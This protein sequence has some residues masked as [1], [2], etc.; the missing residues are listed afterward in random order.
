MRQ[1][2]IDFDILVLSECWRIHN[3]DLFNKEG[4]DIL[5]NFGDINQND[6]VILYI[7]ASLDYEYNTIHFGNINVLNVKIVN[8][9]K[10]IN[11][12]A[13]YR[14]P[15]TC[16]YSFNN[17]LKTFLENNNKKYDINII[18]GDINININN[19]YL[20]YV[21]DYLNILS[22]EG[23]VSF[24]N[25]NTREEGHA[26]SCIDHIFIKTKEPYSKFIPIIW[27][28]KITDHYP[29]MLH[30]YLDDKKKEKTQNYR[31]KKY[32]DY[33]KLKLLIE[34][35]NWEDFYTTSNVNY[36]TNLLIDKLQNNI[37]NCTRTVNIKKKH[38][39]RSAWITRG[40]IKSIET[41]NQIYKRLKK[42]PDNREILTEYKNYRNRLNLLIKNTKIQYYKTQIDKN[43][44]T[45]K[46]LWQCVR[47]I[48]N[49]SNRKTN[50]EKIKLVDGNLTSNKINIANTFA[51]HY[52]NVGKTL[53]S[54]ITKPAVSNSTINTCMNSIYLSPTSI[55]EVKQTIV[56]LKTGKA[57][58]KDEIT[59]EV[60]K[61]IADVI[62]EQ[63]THLINL[64]IE[65][66]ICPNQFKIGIVKPLFKNGDKTDVCNYRPISLIST[67]AKIF[68][69][70]IKTRIT[71]YLNKYKILSNLQFGFRE[72]LSTEDALAHFTKN[73]YES[74]DVSEPT[75]SIFIDLAKAFDTVSHS[76]LLKKLQ[77]IGFRG[78]ALKLMESYLANRT[79]YVKIDNVTSDPKI[80]EYGVPQG[81]VL[82]PLLFNIYLNDLLLLPIKGQILSFADDTTITYAA[83]DWN[84]LK[85]LAEEDFKEVKHW[86]DYN[87]LTINYEKTKYLPFTTYLN[88]LPNLGPLSI[89]INNKNMSINEAESVKYLGVVVDKHLRW[90][91]HITYVI[92]K[93]RTLL[94][95][96][97]YLKIF[98][99]IPQLDTLF[100]SLVQSQIT[101]G[102]IGW[103]G[104]YDNTLNNLNTIH[105]WFL[106]IIYNKNKTYCTNSLFEESKK[107]D[108]RQLFCLKVLL[109]LFKN[110]NL[111]QYNNHIYNT[112]TKNLITYKIKANKSIGQ[113]YYYY[114]G[115]R[116]YDELPTNIKAI[117]SLNIY[118]KNIKLWI[119]NTSRQLINSIFC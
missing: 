39:K 98:L 63:L 78:T 115:L 25:K 33:N 50:I 41:K 4:Y 52:S 37:E 13:I 97:K 6:G 30:Y 19:P 14:P 110:K 105:K 85:K 76:E 112:R 55:E 18:V 82:G 8:S 7:N 26:K 22:V 116:I 114:I 92:K 89:N 99:D 16:P 38:I 1:Q 87:L 94:P 44:S 43:K 54:K 57:P 69:K 66:G 91:L 10:T 109:Y 81:T 48:C 36:A 102:I 24:I 51:T 108:I 95:K 104:V 77:H 53:A 5:Y 2:D 75:L 31:Y 9:R 113:R 74:L 106:K 107:M 100:Y 47:N 67:I 17:E 68:E 101:Y 49:E 117:T 93:L 96:F 20:D 103:G 79:Q 35:D 88:N 46:N 58:G 15:S 27:D 70:V 60:L 84:S 90:N 40:I 12:L 80:I 111:I 34:N 73:I 56:Q 29:I 62:S 42:N 59:A 28:V 119:H 65:E 45:S 11:I 23:Y 64:I 71:K 118:K 86:F 72:G 32:I 83:D 21:Q 3:L 61:K